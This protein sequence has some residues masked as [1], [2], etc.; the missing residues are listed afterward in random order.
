MAISTDQIIMELK[1]NLA[2]NET[3]R[4]KRNG[5]NKPQV[6]LNKLIVELQTTL[7][8]KPM[9]DVFS[10]NLSGSLH[11]SGFSYENESFGV[12]LKGGQHSHHSCSYTL[13]IE[14]QQL[15]KISFMRRKRFSESDLSSLETILSTLMY[16]LR[17]AL[18]YQSAIQSARTDSLTGALNRTSLESVFQQE[19]ARAKRNKSDITVL[20]LDIDHFKQVNDT[21]GHSAGDQALVSLTHCIKRTVREVDSTFRLGG[22]EFAIILNNT[23]TKGAQLLAERLRGAVQQMSI[24]HDNKAFNITTSIGVATYQTGET[25]ESILQ[26]ADKALYEAKGSGRNKVVVAAK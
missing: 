1:K 12:L 21:Y 2:P 24:N 14:D 25:H 8:L 15:G 6:D 5:N 18:M 16:P 4:A 26:R 7:E 17:N 19:I 10:E 3:Y 22:E 23:N 20:M 11:H 9:L 13:S